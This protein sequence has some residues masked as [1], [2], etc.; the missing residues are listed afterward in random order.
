MTQQKLKQLIYTALFAT[1]IFLGTTF[2][3]IPVPPALVH[4]GNALVV[5]SFLAL[6]TTYSM[7]AAC[8]GFGIFDLVSGYMSSVHFTLIESILVILVLS[9][10]YKAMQY[11]DTLANIVTLGVVAGIVKIT[12]IFIRRLIT[13]Y[14]LV[15]N[16]TAFPLALAKM[17]NT[18]ITAGVTAIIVPILYFALKKYL[19]QLFIFKK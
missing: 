6:G 18:F 1:I 12:I 10:V 5:I 17:T 8:V 7:I 9:V 14:L 2:F 19:P 4:I 13:E 11:K 15:G 16:H 3:K